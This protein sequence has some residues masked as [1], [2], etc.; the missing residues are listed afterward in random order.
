MSHR[1]L[2]VSKG[3]DHVAEITLNR[4]EH[5]N[6]F[7]TPM[8]LELTAALQDLDADADVRV[9]I[10]KGAGKVFCAGIDVKELSGKSTLEY[11]EWVE[12]METPLLTM[13][14]LK[15]PVIAQVHGVAAANGAGLVAAADLATAEENARIGLTAINVG[16]NCVGPVLPVSRS[17]GRKRALE[18]LFFGELIPARVALDMGLINRVFPSSELDQETR[19]WAKT[20]AGKSPIALQIAKQAFYTAEDME[21]HKAFDHMNEAFARLCSTEDAKEG[22]AA[23]FEKRQPRWKLR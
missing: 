14:R 5:L 7:N 21:Y 13:S 8:A 22:V 19:T 20:L 1:H 16:L 3:E 6:T 12:R 18:M 23:F 9:M 15:K 4:P 17:V 11:R 2:I 10:L